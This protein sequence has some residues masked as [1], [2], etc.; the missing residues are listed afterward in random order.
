MSMSDQNDVDSDTVPPGMSAGR[1]AVFAFAGGVAVGNL[2]WAQP[3][4]GEIGTALGVSP[5]AAGLLLTV[6]QVGYALGVL[7]IIPLG[8]TMNRRRMLPAVALL[9]AAA[10]LGCAFAPGYAAFLGTLALVGVT[11]VGGQLLT[12]LAGDVARDDQRGRAV[13]T[14]AAGILLGILV[15]RALSGLMADVIGWRGVFGLAAALAVIAAVLLWV[16]VP[17]TPPRDRVP[18]PRLIASV[19]VAVTRHRQIPALL[20]LGFCVMWVFTMFWTALTFFLIAEPF[21]LTLSQIGLVSLVGIF[22]AAAALSVGRLFD[23]GLASPAI[24]VSIVLS[25]VGIAISALGQG[26]LVAVIVAVGVFSIGIQA[27]QVL[28]QTTMLSL[29]PAARSRLNTIFVTV[30]FVGAATGSAVAGVAWSAGGWTL[31]SLIAIGILVVA[32]VLHLVRTRS[33]RR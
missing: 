20:A 9:S 23:R 18:Y 29:D 31:I 19:F 6:T 3:L 32:G 2:Y 10:L 7:F 5:S 13:S 30:N 4:L 16:F 21:H 33:P 1:T 22:G 26:S 24:A 8:D 28:L 14:V 27:C 15:A 25:L 12:P 17:V 11:S